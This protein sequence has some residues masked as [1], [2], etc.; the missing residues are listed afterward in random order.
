MLLDLVTARPH[1]ESGK[2]RNIGQVGNQ[3]SINFPDVPLLSETVDSALTADFW[4]GVAAPAGTPTAIIEKLNKEINA[5][6]NSPAFKT[7]GEAASMIAQNQSP[8]E[9]GDKLSREWEL[10]GNVIRGRNLIIK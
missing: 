8:K 1:I 2:A 6:V 3:R 9:F 10:W 5:V 4:L 7:K